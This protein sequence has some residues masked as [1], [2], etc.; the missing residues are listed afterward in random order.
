MNAQLQT[1]D[2]LLENPAVSGVAARRALPMRSRDCL[3]SQQG[4]A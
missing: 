2:F 3:R 4:H 1:K